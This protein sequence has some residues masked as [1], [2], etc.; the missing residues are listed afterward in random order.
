MTLLDLLAQQG[1][2]T[3]PTA[4]WDEKPISRNK[5]ANVLRDPYYAG[6]I[7][8]KGGLYSGRHEPLIS[9]EL[10]MKVQTVLNARVQRGTRDVR[11]KHWGKGLL[12]CGR[13]EREGTPA[14][15][16]YSEAKGRGGTYEYFLCRGPQL[17]TCD[18]PHVPSATVEAAVE[19]LLGAIAVSEPELDSMRGKI[20]AEVV[21]SQ[22]LERQLQSS[23][24]TELRRLAVKEERLYDR[25]GEEEFRPIG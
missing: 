7:R 18:L 19:R 16:I 13:C 21:N 25:A 23:L 4:A 12:W 1:L 2:T 24:T 9:K 5:L 14:R 10:F 20:E 17:K 6:I 8:Y 22:D 11:H 3:R 15:L